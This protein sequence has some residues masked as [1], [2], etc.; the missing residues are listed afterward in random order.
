MA[1]TLLIGLMEWIGCGDRN[2]CCGGSDQARGS[3]VRAMI[4]ELFVVG[5]EV[6]AVPH[7]SISVE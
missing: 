7:C 5:A 4:N 3:I 2:Y 1:Q 6:D